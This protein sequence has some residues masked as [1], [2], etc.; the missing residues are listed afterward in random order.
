MLPFLLVKIGLCYAAVNHQPWNTSGKTHKVYLY[1]CHMSVSMA[2]RVEG[3]ALSHTV[4]QGPRLGEA[5]TL[6][7][8]HLLR[9]RIRDTEVM[10]GELH[11]P[12]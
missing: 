6:G 10:H 7:C 4:I 12:G 1:A 2:G 5:L 9:L 8:Y 3:E 11:S